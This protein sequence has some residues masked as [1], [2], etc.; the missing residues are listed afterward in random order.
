MHFKCVINIQIDF[1]VRPVKRKRKIIRKQK[2]T[3]LCY[4]IQML[5]S[6]EGIKINVRLRFNKRFREEFYNVDY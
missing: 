5:H 6:V 3:W 1:C 2:S 4:T